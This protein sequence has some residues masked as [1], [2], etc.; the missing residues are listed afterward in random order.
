MYTDI[1]MS[2]ENL[3]VVIKI[4]N[5]L[6]GFPGG[7]MVKNSPAGKTDSVL[8]PGRSHRVL[9]PVSGNK[10]KHCHEKPERRREGAAP[11]AAA[12]DSLCT[13][14]RTHQ[15]VQSLRRVRLCHRQLLELT[16]THVH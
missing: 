4:K 16:Q 15:S 11:L 1:A 9:E 10:R 14:M 12:G 7:S 6:S 5:S 2:E 3:T 13:A 8:D